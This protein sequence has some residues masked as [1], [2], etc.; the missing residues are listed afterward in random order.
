MSLKK[1]ISYAV[2]EL[3]STY[4]TMVLMIGLGILFYEFIPE[5]WGKLTIL[6]IVLIVYVDIKFFSKESGRK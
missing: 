1:I 5:H 2:K 6:S 4:I 3:I